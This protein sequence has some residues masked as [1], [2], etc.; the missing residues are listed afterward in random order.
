[1]IVKRK[2]KKKGRMCLEMLLK[3]V[4]HPPCGAPHLPM[5]GLSFR[6]PMMLCSV[7]VLGF[8]RFSSASGTPIETRSE[9]I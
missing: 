3:G 8:E 4:F 5:L 6:R 7:G 9:N 1:M 2:K